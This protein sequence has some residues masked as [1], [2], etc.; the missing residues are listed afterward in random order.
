MKTFDLQIDRDSLTPSELL[1]KFQKWLEA[2]GKREATIERYAY[3]I[4][5]FIS[6]YDSLTA[7][8]PQIEDFLLD[9]RSPHLRKQALA[10]L[11]TFYKFLRLF[12]LREDNPTELVEY[13]KVHSEL[14]VPLNKEEVERLKQ[15]VK[16]E[17]TPLQQ[18]AIALMLGAGLRVGEVVALR[19]EDINLDRGIAIIRNTKG[20]KDREVVLLPWVIDILKTMKKRRGLVIPRTRETVEKWVRKLGKKALN[21][22]VYP[23]LLRIT[24]ASLMGQQGIPIELIQVQLGH[25]DIS[26]TRKFYRKVS[27]EEL[28]K[29]LSR[30]HF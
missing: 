15:Y 19:W 30:V 18:A 8:R 16:E 26:T 11:R 29:I 14:R 13:P 2:R 7:R 20:G 3:L 1:A 24:F 4:N 6:K 25:E 9:I 12:E 22:R 10:A 23:H 28:V 27:T 17:G 21:K 5:R